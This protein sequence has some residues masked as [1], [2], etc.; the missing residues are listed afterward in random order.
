VVPALI[1]STNGVSEDLLAL[2]LDQCERLKYYNTS[3]I[4]GIKDEV[5]RRKQKKAKKMS[6]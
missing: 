4:S 6:S 3:L 5:E 2:I 1:K